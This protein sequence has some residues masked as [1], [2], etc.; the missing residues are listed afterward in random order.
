MEGVWVFFVCEIERACYH[1]RS[2]K[3]IVEIKLM[4][5]KFV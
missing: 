4:K 3:I 2:V 5:C 1:K